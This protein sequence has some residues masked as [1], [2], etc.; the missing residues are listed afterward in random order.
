MS[1][2]AACLDAHAYVDHS[3]SPAERAKFE[4]A[5][6]RDGKLRARVEAWEA[7]NEAIRAAFGAAPKARQAPPIGR[8]SNE[9]EGNAKTG[10]RVASAPERERAPPALKTPPRAARWPP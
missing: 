3:L 8:P 7:Q 4:A 9:N 5:L 2:G 1:D 10:A 6:S